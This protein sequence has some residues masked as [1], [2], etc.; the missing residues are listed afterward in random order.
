M[1]RGTEFF[2]QFRKITDLERY[3]TE[4]AITCSKY[5]STPVIIGTHGATGDKGDT[6]AAGKGVKSTTVTYQSSTGGTTA[7]TGTWSSSIPAVPAGSYLWSKTEITYTDNSKSTMYS[8]ARMGT[9]GTNGNAVNGVSGT[10]VTYQ[11]ST[12]G[13]TAPTGTWPS[14]TEPFALTVAHRAKGKAQ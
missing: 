13:T 9:N 10:V 4:C 12:S 1:L 14:A 8:V 6:G 7:P 3:F 11:A 5:T 2:A